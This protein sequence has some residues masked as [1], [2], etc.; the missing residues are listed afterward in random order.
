MCLK[1]IFYKNMQEKPS[2]AKPQPKCLK[3]KM[4]K[5]TKVNGL[6]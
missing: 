4:S 2:T 3:C 5:V 1:L 6:L